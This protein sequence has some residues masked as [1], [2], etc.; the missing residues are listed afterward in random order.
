MPTTLN[1]FNEQQDA[2]VIFLNYQSGK[3]KE[4]VESYLKD[5]FED[6][7][8]EYLLLDCLNK[9]YGRITGKELFQ[10]IHQKVDQLEIN[11]PDSQ[12]LIFCSY[13]PLEELD[14]EQYKNISNRVKELAK[15]LPGVSQ[16]HIFCFSYENIKPLEQKREEIIRSLK[17]FGNEFPPEIL[18]SEYLLY[19]AG[20]ETLDMQEHGLARLLH[21][22]SRKDY[23]KAVK[24]T[25]GANYLKMLRYADYYEDRADFCQKEIDKIKAW[26]FQEKDPE[27]NQFYVKTRAVIH[28]ILEEFRRRKNSFEDNIQLYP[29]SISE[30]RRHFFFWHVREV[31]TDHPMIRKQK[32]QFVRD[33]EKEM[34]QNPDIDGLEEY[35]RNE[36]YYEDG[37]ALKEEL[38]SGAFVKRILDYSES[39]ETDEETKIFSV[40]LLTQISEKLLE[41]LE[42]LEQRKINLHK[43]Q[44]QYLRELKEAGR[45]SNLSHCFQ[46]INT[47]TRFSPMSGY[48]PQISAVVTLIGGECYDNWLHMQYDIA[49]IA[50]AYRYSSIYPCEI[51]L[52]KLGNLVNL[53]ENN[54]EEMLNKIL[55]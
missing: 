46:N 38:Q 54:A 47:D 41:S 30:Y 25:Y 31:T 44:Q 27:R 15:L 20:F 37:C 43:K 13:M 52:M 7:S 3:R 1:E 5:C 45:Y 6:F 19:A 10:L 53:S 4:I 26:N 33:I 29:A 35:V 23:S 40:H 24:P 36:L 8:T 9:E 11:L 2:L 50:N 51:V 18:Y 16:Q 14:E 12:R 34:L 21:I 48:F 55:D 17:N 32:K 42:D 28:S 39:A 22:L 49:E